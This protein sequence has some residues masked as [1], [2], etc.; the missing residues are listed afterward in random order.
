LEK[1]EKFS[2]LKNAAGEIDADR[3]FNALADMESEAWTK[4]DKKQKKID[5]MRKDP[6]DKQLKDLYFK[7]NLFNFISETLGPNSPAKTRAAETDRKAKY[8]ATLREFTKTIGK[9]RTL[10]EVMDALR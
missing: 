4:Y 8:E 9:S 7:R 1:I 2:N 10:D 5:K 3:V 6:T